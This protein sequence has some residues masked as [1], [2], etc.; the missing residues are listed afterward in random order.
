MLLPQIRTLGRRQQQR[1]PHHPSSQLHLQAL[2]A[3]DHAGNDDHLEEYISTGDANH[4][5]SLIVQPMHTNG[6]W[7]KISD[8][9]C[10]KQSVSS[11]NGRVA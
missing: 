7:S 5:Q 9:H 1:V 2:L 10:F 8:T 4:Y 11:K 3:A 6:E